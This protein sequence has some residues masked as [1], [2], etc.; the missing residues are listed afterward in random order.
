MD[1]AKMIF[2]RKKIRIHT[3]IKQVYVQNWLGMGNNKR[4]DKIL[5]EKKIWLTSDMKR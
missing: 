2:Y 4:G 5:K 1:A 3:N